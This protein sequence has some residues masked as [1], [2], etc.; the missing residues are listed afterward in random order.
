MKKLFISMLLLSITVI[1]FA[2]V[3]LLRMGKKWVIVENGHNT[4]RRIFGTQESCVYGDHYI[5][6]DLYYMTN[7]SYKFWLR[8]DTIGQKIYM[9]NR[10]VREK[11]ERLL[12]DFS[13][14]PGDSAQIFFED[15]LR[16]LKEIGIECDST[17]YGKI[18]ITKVDSVVDLEGDTLRRFTYRFAT[19]SKDS[20]GFYIEKYGAIDR[21]F[22]YYNSRKLD[23]YTGGTTNY[24]RCVISPE[25]EVTFH[26]DYFEEMF[27]NG[28]CYYHPPVDDDTIP[29]AGGDTIP[30]GG[31]DT[32]PGAGGDTIPIVIVDTAGVAARVLYNQGM[33]VIDGRGASSVAVYAIDGRL[34]YSSQSLNRKASIPLSL[35][36]GVY[37]AVFVVD[38]RLVS[39]KFVASE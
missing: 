22:L 5:G 15:D 7:F 14:Q 10:Y 2:Y 26:T 8:E 33:L 39:E 30:G 1:S 9:R 6:F 20:G 19:Y 13:L 17:T 28:D 29:G 4:D 11:D 35:P 34:I 3:P 24:L 31:S 36:A 37:T 16:Q 18:Y 12:Y 23:I 27:E 32:I 38:D 25:G 21:D